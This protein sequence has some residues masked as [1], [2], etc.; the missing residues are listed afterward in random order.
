VP[1][2]THSPFIWL[3]LGPLRPDP[4]V[5]VIV[6]TT[7]LCLPTTAA[8]PRA[9]Q[10]TAQFPAAPCLAAAKRVVV[11]AVPSAAFRVPIVQTVAAGA[12]AVAVP[13]PAAVPGTRNP[14][15]IRQTAGGGVE[16]QFFLPPHLV[17]AAA[18]AVAAP[19]GGG[20]GGVPRAPGAAAA[21]VVVVVVV[22]A[23]VVR[24]PRHA[25][26][27]VVVQRVAQQRGV[28]VVATGK[29]NKKNRKKRRT[30]QNEK[31]DKG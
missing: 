9:A 5:I 26:A 3:L 8:A 27:V 24:P 18:A 29:R 28:G 11:A 13:L 2:L 10:P 19:G 14:V 30:R 23:V 16:I 21:T 31:K 6:L 20:G 7:G 17:P 1:H 22:V 15:G 12:A 4:F 25:V